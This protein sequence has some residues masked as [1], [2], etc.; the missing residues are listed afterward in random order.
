[1]IAA[2]RG[3][4]GLAALIHGRIAEI[5]PVLRLISLPA[6]RTEQRQELE[7]LQRRLGPE[8]FAAAEADGASMS[9]EQVTAAAT[10]YLT[11]IRPADPP[12]VAPVPGLQLTG[13]QLTGR[14]LDVVRLLAEGCT[15]KEIAS[16]LGVTPKTVMHHTVAIYQRLGVRGRSEAVAWAIRAGIAAGP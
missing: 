3:E 15:N 6:S 4:A 11:A 9:W 16:K 7:D 12:P 5:Q 1:M 8:R 10:A 14:Q 13:R 2:R